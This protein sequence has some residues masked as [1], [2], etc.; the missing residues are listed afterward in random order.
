MNRHLLTLAA[1]LL[2]A[3]SVQAGLNGSLSL[4]GN[5]ACMPLSYAAVAAADSTTVS[6]AVTEFPEQA[7]QFPGGDQAC[8]AFIAS[9]MRYPT[10]AIQEGIAG[11][12]V[13]RF[14]VEKDGSLTDITVMRSP[15]PV[16]SK[17]AV[18]IVRS[19]P[20]WQPAMQGGVAVRSRYL[21]TL[22]FKLN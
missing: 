12:V 15:A 18:R 6:P 13:V 17:E 14:V 9:H 22:T 10:K 1:T 2:L 7:A 11:R 5:V 16:L 4:K 3:G 19:M 20:R 21:L 8:Y